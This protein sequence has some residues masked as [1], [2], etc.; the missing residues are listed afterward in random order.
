MPSVTEGEGEG[1]LEAA[2]V[3]FERRKAVADAERTW[4]LTLWTVLA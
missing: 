4:T 1:L 2:L 3:L